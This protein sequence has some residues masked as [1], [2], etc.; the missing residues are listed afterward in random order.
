LTVTYSIG[1]VARTCGAAL[2]VLLAV[3]FLAEI[4]GRLSTSAPAAAS[5]S[6]TTA[7]R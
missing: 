2:G 1:T 4:A 6:R 5:A 3:L 7:R